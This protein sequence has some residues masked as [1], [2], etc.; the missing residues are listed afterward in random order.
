MS[1][2]SRR[3][4]IVEETYQ[5]GSV[6]TALRNRL[7]SALH[8]N[9]WKRW[10]Y[11]PFRFRADVTTDSDVVER[12]TKALWL[13]YLKLPSDAMPPHQALQSKK[14]RYG[15]IRQR[16]FTGD[17]WDVLDILEFVHLHAPSE[18]SV[19]LATHV[20]RCLEEENSAYR[21]VD[22]MA[23]EVVSSIDLDAID[24]ALDAPIDEVRYHLENALRLLSSGKN[25]DYSNSIKE[26]VCAI[27]AM[28][29]RVTGLAKATAGECIRVLESSERL[30]PAF[31]KALVAMYGFSSD[32]GGI[33]HAMAPGNVD[34]TLAYANLFLVTASAFVGF[35]MEWLREQGGSVPGSLHE[36]PSARD[37]PDSIPEVA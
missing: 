31:A 3:H 30:H 22:G 6:S 18:W 14:S 19:P 17:W 1:L 16:F 36:S 28:S 9:V 35:C 26:S 8:E 37:D 33:R 20:N 34:P 21:F 2:F 23:T 27:E 25:P 7:W 10:V 24:K 5:K 29:R 32:E 12:I 4:Q 11:D 13:D 15:L